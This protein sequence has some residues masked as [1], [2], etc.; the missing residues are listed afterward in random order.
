MPAGVPRKWIHAGECDGAV[1]I[2][3]MVVGTGM[4]EP[5]FG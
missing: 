3:A 2:P 1:F 4:F 5:G